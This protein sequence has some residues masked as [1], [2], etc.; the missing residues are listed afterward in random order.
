M[1]KAVTLINGRHWQKQGD[2]IEHFKQML[3]QYKNGDRI[4]DP[5]D[6]SDL[7]A[8]LIP[9]DAC[10]APGE[11]VKIGPGVDYFSRQL[12]IGDGYAT[13]GFHVHRVDGTSIDFSYI[14]AVKAASKR[15]SA[16]GARVKRANGRSFVL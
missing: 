3:A 5:Q 1:A 2:A 4:T 6:H 14:Q 15:N 16:T 12:N 9:Y 8:L 11:P 13:S 7:G 10:L